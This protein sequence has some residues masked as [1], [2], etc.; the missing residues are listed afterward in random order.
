MGSST[1]HGDGGEI[2]MDGAFTVP[3]AGTLIA[4]CGL[5]GSG[6]TT[7]ISRLAERLRG[8]HRVHCT[9]QPTGQFRSDPVMRAF[10]EGRMT[11]RDAV[12]VLPEI[13]LLA[14]ADR[15]RH[16]RTEVMPRLRRGEVVISDRWV[17]T[18][19]AYAG[20]RGL[21]DAEWIR[22]LN[23]YLPAPDLTIY[24]DVPPEVALERIRA[25]GDVPRWEEVDLDR[26]RAI[27]ANFVNQ[28][29]GATPNYH[30]LD[31]LAPLDRLSAHIAELADGVLRGVGQR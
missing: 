31:G 19:H 29:W 25:R 30:V 9:R 13:A 24:L 2:A 11:G 3:D 18:S 4:F 27:R 16:V 12:E 10:I 14:A 5:D 26:M 28:S 8:R 15:F 7:Q 21:T 20:P 23:R 6:K 17:Y 22:A 1:S